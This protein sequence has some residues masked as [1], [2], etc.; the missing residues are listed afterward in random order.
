MLCRIFWSL[1]IFAASNSRKPSV[2]RHLR[3]RRGCWIQ[4]VSRLKPHRRAN[5][6]NQLSHN[7]CSAIESSVDV[8]LMDSF[9]HSINYCSRFSLRCYLFIVVYRTRVNFSTCW[10]VGQTWKGKSF[11]TRLLSSYRWVCAHIRHF[12]LYYWVSSCSCAHSPYIHSRNMQRPC[13]KR[14]ER[15]RTLP[16]SKTWDLKTADLRVIFCLTWYN[17]SINQ[18]VNA[19]FVG[20]RYTTHPGASTIV[21]YKHDQKVNS[22][23]VFWMYWYQLC[24][25]SRMEECSRRL[26]RS[27]RSHVLQI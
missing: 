23:V 16:P 22:W 25:E 1:N 19:R 26:D 12:H 10:Q 17:R 24:R 2:T 20:R 15:I 11:Y 21:S 7:W 13:R 9:P 8:R 6:K 27:R 3:W 5:N 4:R 14:V 18:S